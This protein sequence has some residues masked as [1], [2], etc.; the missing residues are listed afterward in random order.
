M[1]KSLVSSLVVAAAACCVAGFFCGCET[2]SGTDFLNVSPSS[3]NTSNKSEVITFTVA[4]STNDATESGLKTLSLPLTW[5]VSNPLLGYISE[6]SGYSASYV[7]NRANGIN[8]ISVKDQ[9]GAEGHATVD[10]Q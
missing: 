8:T 3:V 9:Y 1:K 7:R 4:A 5:S 6:S 10:Q 2:G